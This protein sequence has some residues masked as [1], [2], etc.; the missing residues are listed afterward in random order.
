MSI[1]YVYTYQFERVLPMTQKNSLIIVHGRML[2]LDAKK[3]PRNCAKL[4]CQK[5]C[6]YFSRK[7][8]VCFSEVF[9]LG[10]SLCSV[11]ASPNTVKKITMSSQK[12]NEFRQQITMPVRRRKIEKQKENK[13]QTNCNQV[14]FLRGSLSSKIKIVE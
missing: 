4:I 12:L 11:A 5:G 3:N 14:L 7:R 10:S 9:A 6:I 1:V 13:N 8:V 2:R